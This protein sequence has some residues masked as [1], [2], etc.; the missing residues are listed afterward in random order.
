[1]Y[2]DKKYMFYHH[3]S[4]EKRGTQE[5]RDHKYY[6]GFSNIITVSETNK[7]MLL[8]FFPELNKKIISIHN[9]IEVDSIL[10]KSKENTV[11]FSDNNQIKICTVGRLSEEKGQLFA[12][13]VAKKLEEKAVEFEWLFVGDGSTKEECM[14]YIMQ[15]NL[16][17]KCRLVGEKNN[18][19]PYIRQADIYVQTSTVEADP[20]TIHEAVVLDKLI[21]AS[22]IDAVKEALKGYSKGYVCELDAEL[23]SEKILEILKTKTEIKERNVSINSETLQKFDDLF[24]G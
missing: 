21:V 22:S 15:N 20:I 24:F 8:S 17:L 12:L 9:L 6:A 18:P 10:N 11:C 3:G 13:E 19:Y 14:N 23:F 5:K 16:Q 2:A 1:M 4:Y 7:R